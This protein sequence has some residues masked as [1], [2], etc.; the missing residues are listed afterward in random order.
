MTEKIDIMTIIEPEDR[1]LLENK[2]I[3]T[4]SKNDWGKTMAVSNQYIQRNLL[5]HLLEQYHYRI[6]CVDDAD[7]P[8]EISVY[9]NATGFDLVIIS[10]LNRIFRIQS[11]LRQVNG[12]CNFSQRIHFETTRRNSRKNKE[13]S[14]TGHVCYS[15]NEFDFVMISLVNERKGRDVIQNCNEWSFSFIPIHELIDNTKQ[16]CI[17][18]IPATLL[19][20]YTIHYNQNILHLFS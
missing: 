12:L 1:F 3:S 13:K 14:H 5:R 2:R 6:Y 18:T 15:V 20:K 16:C 4:M 8:K 10:P 11:K 19:S 7:F 17:S 9:N